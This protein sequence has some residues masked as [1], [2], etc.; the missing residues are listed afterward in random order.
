MY[1]PKLK[2]GTRKNPLKF[3]MSRKY[4]I[5]I[6]Q[7]VFSGSVL[8][9]YHLFHR[10]KDRQRTS[11]ALLETSRN[12]QRVVIVG[13]GA[14][15]CAVA[16]ALTAQDPTLQ[17]TVF[18]P[19]RELTFTAQIP[20]AHAGHRSYDLNT[21]A[22][23]DFLY[24]PTTWNVVRDAKLVLR[25]VDTIDPAT[26]TLV[27]SDGQ[28]HTYDCLVV[29]T[30]ASPDFRAIPGLK[31]SDYDSRRISCS[32]QYTRD[33]LAH[34]YEG[35]LLHVKVPPRNPTVVY[36]ELL[37]HRSKSVLESPAP[38]WKRLMPSSSNTSPT[39]EKL[40][41]GLS[42]DRS[43]DV[44]PVLP[45][46][47]VA[48]YSC[49][50]SVPSVPPFLGQQHP[51][52]FIGTSNIIWKYLH[53]F[54]KLINCPMT[55]VSSEAQPSDMLP[56]V[57]NAVI[58][59]F[60]EKRGMRFLNRTG[61]E[62][63]DTSD[64]MIRLRHLDTGVTQEMK[65]RLMVVDLPVIPSPWIVQNGLSRPELGG[66]VDVNPETLQHRRYPN[67]FALGDCA[68]V[69]TA[70]S[71]S[72][73]FCQA[74]VV[75]HNV[76]QVLAKK[77]AAATYSGYSS[78]NVVMTTWRHMWPEMSWPQ[79]GHPS[80]ASDSDNSPRTPVAGLLVRREQHIWDDSKW[81]D[82]RGFLQGLYVQW[83]AYE[84]MHWFVFMR[85]GWHPEFWY[86]LP[87]FPENISVPSQA[88]D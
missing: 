19:Q 67:I 5:V 62:H 42:V 64:Q 81:T 17:V 16:S 15:G 48:F 21:H 52:T 56:A 86:Q 4:L 27:D 41:A 84:I 6:G 28:L 54:K 49:N 71:Y 85:S 78:F 63:V 33:T 3:E 13:G 12:G 22:G 65:Y 59:N 30:G 38:W 87:Q 80:P 11:D 76:R 9:L 88:L 53:F 31:E 23:H 39:K 77:P 37:Q 61:I 26:N 73:A 34:M 72:A 7:M 47:S 18:E 60:W 20:Y 57:Y 58:S 69:P 75:A 44:V 43:G 8:F 74:P 14:A 66:F 40:V 35:N 24:S 1:I 70:K 83:F 36:S 50:T 10:I 32:P 82:I 29:A 68:A 25:S 45:Q 51:G 55:I 46:E 79:K 2:K